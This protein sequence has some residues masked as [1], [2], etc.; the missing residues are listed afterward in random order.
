MKIKDQPQNEARQWFLD[1][2]SDNLDEMSEL[3]FSKRA[4][5]ARFYFFI[6]RKSMF[7]N[8]LQGPTLRIKEESAERWAKI[9]PNYPWKENLKIVQEELKKR[10]HT[11][12]I[13]RPMDFM[14][15]L[16]PVFLFGGMVDQKIFMG[17]DISETYQNPFEMD[18]LKKHSVLS[19]IYV[20]NELPKDAIKSCQE[21]GRYFLHL[22]KKEK[23][24]C[25]PKCTSRAFSKKRRQGENKE[26]YKKYQREVMR[27]KRRVESGL[28]PKKFYKDRRIHGETTKGIRKE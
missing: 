19:M 6:H 25:S 12:L 18:N 10:L 11:M 5:E 22:S 7:Q 2:I 15:P 1:F 26:S 16:F 3:K 14:R 8:L 13:D 20:F 9:E 27:D 4:L 28:R 21:C 17:L 24:F 23:L